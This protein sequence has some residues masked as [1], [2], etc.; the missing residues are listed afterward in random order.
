MNLC[1]ARRD[2]CSFYVHASVFVAILHWWAL[3]SRRLELHFV[4]EHGLFLKQIWT[5]LWTC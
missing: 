4:G 5:L 2:L 1:S 3:I